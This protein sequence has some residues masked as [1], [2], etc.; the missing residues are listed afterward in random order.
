MR[1]RRV[2]IVQIRFGLLAMFMENLIMKL[3]MI[4]TI[5]FYEIMLEL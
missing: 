4:Y 5:F 3:L 2:A 1:E